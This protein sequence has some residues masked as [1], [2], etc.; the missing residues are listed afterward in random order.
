MRKLKHTIYALI[1]IVAMSLDAP[2]QENTE[3]GHGKG[4]RITEDGS[5]AEAPTELIRVT[6]QQISKKEPAYVFL[7]TNLSELPVWGFIVGEGRSI[8]YKLRGFDLNIP[9][10]MESPDGWESSGF[11][12]ER[13][14]YLWQVKNFE[15]KDKMI[16]PGKSVS[17]IRIYLPEDTRKVPTFFGD[18]MEAI[19]VKFNNL[20][21]KVSIS[22][23]SCLWGII[24]TVDYID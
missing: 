12:G 18:G 23:G 22:G 14:Y 17:N 20:S 3:L 16:M 2:A 8:D 5:C 24:K 9:T 4:D 7:V 6:V 11:P 19:Q 13:F 21:F 10:K 15:D 1:I